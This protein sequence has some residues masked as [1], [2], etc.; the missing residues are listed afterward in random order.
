MSHGVVPVD[1]VEL[2][3]VREG[4]GPS[5]LVI[6]SATYYPRAFSQELRQHYDCIFPDS[7]HFVPSFVPE[8][9]A[10]PLTVDDFADDVEAV[11]QHL[12][13]ERMV[14]LGHS[15]HAQIAISYARRYQN[16]TSHLALVC[17][18]PYA[19]AEFQDAATRFVD[20]DAS[21][22]RKSALREGEAGL[23]EQLATAPPSRSF[24]VSYLARGPLYWADYRYDATEL[25]AG[26]ENGPAFDQLFGAVPSKA[27]VRR[28]LEEIEVPVLLVL[29]KLDFAIPYVTWEP[30]IQG[31][32]NV[33]YVRLDEDSHNPQTE[34]PDRFDATL[35]DWFTRH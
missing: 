22:E 27:A 1:G 2:K 16:H 24:A 17:G 5:L 10:T 13:I 9:S 11:R 32:E 7:R 30:L 15:V 3:Y 35:V 20:E 26:L 25:L 31:L 18:V 19:F 28:S 34:S 14:V 21:A 12:G 23:N 8:A 29:G 6:G 4:R 33:T